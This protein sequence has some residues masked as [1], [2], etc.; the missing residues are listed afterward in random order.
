MLNEAQASANTELDKVLELLCELLQPTPTLWKDAQQ[1]YQAAGNWLSAPKSQLYLLRPEIKY[2]GSALIETVVRPWQREEYDVDLL[3]ILDTDQWRH[4]DPTAVYDLVADRLAE[5]ATYRRL[6]NRKERCIEL[7]YAGQF[8]LD[9][10]PAIPQ[11]GSPTKLLIPDRA[12]KVWLPTDPFGYT[13]WFFGRT[14]VTEP[15]VEHYRARAD[16]EPLRP[17]K[18]AAQISPLQR[19]VQLMKRR[20]DLYFDGNGDAPKSIALTTLAAKHY[21][22]QAV[23]TDALLGALDGIHAE[24]QRSP[25]ILVIPNP[26]DTRENLGRHWNARSYARFTRFTHQFSEEIQ[27]LLAMR[28]WDRITEALESL[29]GERAR[30]AVE[31]YAKNIEAQRRTSNLGYSTGPV[32][33]TP[34]AAPT[35]TVPRNEFYGR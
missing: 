19:T 13:N 1:K 10:V 9:I 28:G 30:V 5:H 25:G 32:I 27:E 7:D 8:H 29:F 26:V 18:R 17:A 33:L 15:L 4:P 6:M 12:R 22:G 35:H 3:C 34:S 20:R 14:P 16:V 2:Q 23:S 31:N 11:L 21:G 24:I